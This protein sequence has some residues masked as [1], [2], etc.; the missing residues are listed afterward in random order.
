MLPPLQG[1]LLFRKNCKTCAILWIFLNKGAWDWVIAFQC[2]L[3]NSLQ[4]YWLDLSHTVYSSMQAFFHING[5]P[6]RF[7]GIF[8]DSFSLT[9][10]CVESQIS[11]LPFGIH[12]VTTSLTRKS[13]V[14][15]LL[16]VHSL[17]C[18]LS[19]RVRYCDFH[20]TRPRA[21]IKCARFGAGR[22]GVWLSAGSWQDL[23]NWYCSLLTRRTVCGRSAGNTISTQNRSERNET[24]IVQTQS[25]RY[26]T[27]VVIKCQ[28]QTTMKKKIFTWLWLLFTAVPFAA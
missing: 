24:E 14:R 5:S 12:M 27:F 20:L 18:G 19:F 17:V 26:K 8:W 23:V 4:N 25:W 9:G 3:G 7:Q 28:Q 2:F 22:S 13:C 6:F 10:D 11:T 21:G 15:W 16:S 1:I